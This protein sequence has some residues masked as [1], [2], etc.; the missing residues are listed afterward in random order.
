MRAFAFHNLGQTAKGKPHYDWFQGLIQ[1]IRASGDGKSA[2][3]AYVTISVPE[4]YSVLSFLGLKI[5]SRGT[6]RDPIRDQFIVIDETGEEIHVWFN[7]AAHFARM[8][9]WA[10]EVSKELGNKK[11]D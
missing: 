8:A 5:K 2:E 9:E 10:K 1:S 11:T 3:T 7:P 6:T 4:E